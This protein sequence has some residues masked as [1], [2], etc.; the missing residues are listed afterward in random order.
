MLVIIWVIINHQ[1]AAAILRIKKHM[2]P[3][4]ERMSP[5]DA[6]FFKIFTHLPVGCS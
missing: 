2:D 6:S 5:L 3:H 1:D 4:F